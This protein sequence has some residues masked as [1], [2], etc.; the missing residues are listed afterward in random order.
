MQTTEK[1]KMFN[2]ID[3]QKALAI[4]RIFE[5]GRAKARYDA[6][7]VLDDG[8]GISYG[9]FQFTHR[10][11]ALNAV[12]KKYL[13]AGGKIGRDVIESRQRTL[14]RTTKSAI[15]RLSKDTEFRSALIAAAD[16]SEM[17]EAQRAV[18]GKRYIAP[19]E[20]V[21]RMNEFE[22]PLA[23]AVVLDGLV[24]GSFGRIARLVKGSTEQALITD[25]LRR[26]DAWLRSSQRLRKTVY[27]TEFFLGEA[28]K[29]NWQLR[30][31]VTVNGRKLSAE[32][33]DDDREAAG[34]P[35]KSLPETSKTEPQIPATELP[36]DEPRPSI[37]ATAEAAF[38]QVD[39]VVSGIA[40]RTERAR[41]LWATVAGTLWQTLWAIVAFVAGIPREIWVIT[42]VAAA[43]LT[44]VY[45]YRQHTSRRERANKEAK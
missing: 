39:D 15:E 5:T 16:S 21:C 12:V 26:R 30:L 10:S 20:R 14:A 42:A 3:K 22:T 23:L 1:G 6:L 35:P 38:D 8:A 41:S 18:A 40:T 32:D 2:E 36:A 27:R 17:R 34:F 24:H 37:L 44:A 11:G 45:L 28:A 29:G 13:A 31:P 33:L 19:A 25:Y 7:A 43:I 4:L 9:F